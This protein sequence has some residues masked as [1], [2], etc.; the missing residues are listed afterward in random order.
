MQK[1]LDRIFSHVKVGGIVGFDAGPLEA[2]EPGHALLKLQLLLQSARCSRQQLVEDVIAPLSL[3]LGHDPRLLQEVV[4]D[5][6]Y[7]CMAAP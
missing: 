7:I 5:L 4:L 1:T 2:L 3:S 6:S